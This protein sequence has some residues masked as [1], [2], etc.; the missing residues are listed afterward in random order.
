MS[1]ERD[2]PRDAQALL[3]LLTPVVKSWSSE[4]GIA[5]NDLAIQV[6]SGYGYTRDFDVALRLPLFPRMRVAARRR[7]ACRRG[8]RQ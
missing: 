3:G 7:M 8:V 4:N 6:H 5:A 2:L 1:P